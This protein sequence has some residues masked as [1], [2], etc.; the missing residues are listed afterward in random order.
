[1]YRNLIRII[2]ACFG[3]LIGS[4]LNVCIYRLPKHE[5]IVLTPS[6]C[7]NC[8]KR[9]KWFELIPVL[10]FL[11]QGGK[12]RGC[13]TKLSVQYPIIELLNGLLYLLVVS[14]YGMT[15]QSLIY[16][17][18]ASVLIVIS[19]IDFRTYEIPVGCNIFI[20]IL[21][22]VQVGFDLPHISKYVIGFFAVSLVLFM[23]W[24]ISKG[25]AIGGGDV[26]LLAA[27]GLLLG[28]QNVILAFVLGCILGAI[29]HLLRM[30]IQGEGRTLAF[31]PYLSMGVF[32]AA[33][34]GD[35]LVSLYLGYLGF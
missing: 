21:G 18:L 3:V 19:V 15:V 4:F 30:K 14:I 27:S 10:S 9:L 17:L 32:I 13:K 35:K 6:H 28:W 2:I 12:C 8:G 33:L 25:R 24:L 1:M 26:K 16:C 34:F 5:D 31:G 22:I 11:V 7:M 29:I 23:I 20:L